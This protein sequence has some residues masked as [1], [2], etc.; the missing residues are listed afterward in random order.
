[1]SKKTMLKPNNGVI[2]E[3]Y[4]YS[5]DGE[6][7]SG[8]REYDVVVT[9]WWKSGDLKNTAK[10]VKINDNFHYRHTKQNG[11]RK[12]DKI[13]KSFTIKKYTGSTIHFEPNIEVDL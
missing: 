3:T 6:Y 1:M 9:D 8:S 5:L 13:Y 7:Y 4:S 2:K 10:E 11:W 12:Y